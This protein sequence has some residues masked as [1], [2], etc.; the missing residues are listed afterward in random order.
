MKLVSRKLQNIASKWFF[1]LF[2]TS[3][4]LTIKF[5]PYWTNIHVYEGKNNLHNKS[6]VT[7]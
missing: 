1:Y 5:I 7:A 2:K 6:N 4:A 3:L